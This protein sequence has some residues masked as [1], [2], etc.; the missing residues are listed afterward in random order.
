MPA[1]GN[2]FTAISSGNSLTG[3]RLKLISQNDAESVPFKEVLVSETVLLQYMQLNMRTERKRVDF[4]AWASG[5]LTINSSLYSIKLYDATKND[6]IQVYE[7]GRLL[8][9]TIEYTITITGGGTGASIVLVFGIP[10]AR[11]SAII[12]GTKTF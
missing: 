1:P 12:H 9:P 6:D 4:G 3:T 10:G 8:E 5:A 2:T 7:G 11:Y